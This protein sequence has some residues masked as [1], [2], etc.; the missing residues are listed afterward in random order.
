MQ[1]NTSTRAD[2]A[3]EWASTGL[4]VPLALILV[5]IAGG[6]KEI[7][8]KT[9]AAWIVAVWPSAPE[10]MWRKGD[11]DVKDA[12]ATFGGGLLTLLTVLTLRLFA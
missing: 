7:K 6:A 4:P 2:V 1:T 10:W 11:P 9:G 3:T 5:L 12:L 8:D